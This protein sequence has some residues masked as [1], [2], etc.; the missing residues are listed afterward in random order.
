MDTLVVLLAAYLLVVPGLA[1]ILVFIALKRIRY[2][3]RRLDQAEQLSAPPARK[4]QADS[5]P[6]QTHPE[7]IWERPLPPSPEP[8]PAES[9][10]TEPAAPTPSKAVPPASPP[11]KEPLPAA[12]FEASTPPRPSWSEKLRKIGLWPP[13]T[14]T[15]E[16]ELI[17]MQWWL[18]RLG[19]I[20]ALLAALFFSVYV[21]RYS[22]PGIRFAQLLGASCG[23][24]GIGWFLER[25]HRSFGSVLV[26][27]GLIM[28]YFTSV[29]AY[30]LPPVRVIESILVGV[31]LQ[32]AALAVIF[33]VGLARRSEG[34]LLLAFHFGYFL[35]VFMAWEGLREG[36]L[37]AAGT[38]T[39]AGTAIMLRFHYR[40]IPWVCLPGALVAVAAW[41][42]LLYALPVPFP[43]GLLTLGYI[44][45]IAG[46]FLAL[47]RFGPLRQHPQGRAFL[48]LTVGAPAAAGLLFFR[49]GLPDSLDLF[50][51]TYALHLFAWAMLYQLRSEKAFFQ[52]QLLVV[53][54]SA[55][56]T[57]WAMLYFVGDIRWFAIALQG[58]VLAAT[59]RRSRSVAIEVTALL[60][61]GIAT[62][63]FLEQG[64]IA[65]PE[66]SLRWALRLAF[67]LVLLTTV[68]WMYPAFKGATTKV[69]ATRTLVYGTAA[70]GI[71]WLWVQI[72][73]LHTPVRYDVTLLLSALSLVALL[74]GII[75][76]S[77][78]H[79]GIAAALLHTAAALAFW[80]APYSLP[81]LLGLIIWSSMAIRA[82][83]Q[84][85]PT[86]AA[87]GES[88]VYCLLLPAMASAIMA[89]LNHS[90]FSGAALFGLGALAL[91]IAR[92]VSGPR[93][94][95]GFWILPALTYLIVE[96]SHLPA[97]GAPF[98]LA[99]GFGLM[100]WPALD[101]VLRSRFGWMNAGQLWSWLAGLVWI[102]FLLGADRSENWLSWQLA[103]AAAA[104]ALL[105]L[106]H[107]ARV[108]GYLATGCALLLLGLFYLLEPVLHGSSWL[109]PNPPVLSIVGSML[110]LIAAAFIWRFVSAPT[111]P[112]KFAP[113]TH[114]ALDG[115]AALVVFAAGYLAASNPVLGLLPYL[116][117]ILAILAVAIILTGF[118]SRR[119][120][121]RLTGLVLLAL[122]LIRLFAYDIQEAFY[123]IVAFAA[124]ALC[125]TGLGYLYHRASARLRPV[126]PPPAV[127]E[128]VTPADQHVQEEP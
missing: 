41:P 43:N 26:V 67:P 64:R 127:S 102:A 55:F 66:G 73:S 72:A 21:A 28:L 1:L 99:L 77:R 83:R 84:T 87:F 123:R 86:R 48:A 6:T 82:M 122:P 44:H 14:R 54:G 8:P 7:I 42:F 98:A 128:S 40:S 23:V 118:I 75:S 116:T 124:A 65:T 24:G 18:P 126:P 39:L 70:V 63:F 15:G 115:F 36:S 120:S 95:A 91:L 31:A 46:L 117:P 69:L 56:A 33:W 60:T 94:L 4:A 68:A 88:A 114:G 10:P 119:Q 85:S 100:L 12:A 107:H 113:S 81:A 125:L 90:P 19:G 58:A 3:H 61:A 89:E 111:I 51:G 30:V 106:A 50:C 47:Q 121:F 53:K 9:F 79:L 93:H 27:T 52:V 59:A 13:E 38:L 74:P 2:L 29:A 71:G 101:P 25:R 112:G 76:F 45:A 110:S 92:A 105:V 22:G 34:I 104:T 16:S 20:L 5:P 103:I 78:L 17:L 49:F 37:L 80:D 57:L 11:I 35:S 97:G 109:R 62:A 96:G 32:S 108:W